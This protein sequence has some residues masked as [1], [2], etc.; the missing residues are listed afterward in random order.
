MSNVSDFSQSVDTSADLKFV[1][2][3]YECVHCLDLLVHSECRC[4]HLVEMARYFIS[5]R[6]IMTFFVI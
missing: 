2:R 3:A 5:L 4:S 1:R 6:K